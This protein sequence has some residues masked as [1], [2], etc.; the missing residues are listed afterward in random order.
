MNMSGYGR[1]FRERL[2]GRWGIVDVND[3]CSCATFLVI[4]FFFS[5]SS[6]YVLA[7]QASWDRSV[8]VNMHLFIQVGSGKA[9]EKRLCI[10]GGSAGGYTTLAALA[11]RDTFKAGASLYGVSIPVV[12]SEVLWSISCV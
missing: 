9:D 5:F 8:Y 7:V 3:C 12:I 6:C 10:T 2:L 4:T 1:E 11:F